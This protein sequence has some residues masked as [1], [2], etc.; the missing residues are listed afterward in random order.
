MKKKIAFIMSIVMMGSMFTGCGSSDDSSSSSR[1]SKKSSASTSEASDEEDDEEE[2]SK[3]KKEKKTTEA[4]TETETEEE[5][6]AE[7]EEEK[8]IELPTKDENA[9]EPTTEEKSAAKGTSYKRGEVK[10]GVFHSDYL[11]IDFKTP[12]GWSELSEAQMF[13]I[14][15]VGLEITGN[16]DLIDEALLEQAMIYDYAAKS[17]GNGSITFSL[18]NLKKENA[19]LAASYTEEDYIEA[20]N[21]QLKN[22]NSITFEEVTSPEKIELCGNTYY[23]VHQKAS[24][25]GS[26]LNQAYYIRK[27]DDFMVLLVFTSGADGED[28]TKYEANFID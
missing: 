14:M 21:Q 26:K 1:S 18:E 23:K 11:G 15:N 19:A 12:E 24:Y 22:V 25:G 10:D 3:S 6:E 13:S 20:L 28:M 17:P 16:S 2:A 8:I 5:T 7:T 9:A 27:L 4:E